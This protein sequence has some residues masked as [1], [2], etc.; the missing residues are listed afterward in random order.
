MNK[1]L[2][3]ESPEVTEDIVT[4]VRSELKD[5]TRLVIKLGYIKRDDLKSVVVPLFKG[6]PLIQGI[7]GINTI[8]M[9][10]L[11]GDGS[12]TFVGTEQK[13][14][15]H[16]TE[17][18]VSGIAIREYGLAFVRSLADIRQEYGL[19]F[20]II[21]MGGVMDAADVDAYQEAGADAVQTATA[22]FFNANLP[23]EIIRR[24][25]APATPEA[26]LQARSGIL[27]LLN[28]PDASQRTG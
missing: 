15:A 3:C 21:G 1:G 6:G 22:A 4:R 26:D 11:K 16:R 28:R 9:K 27:E 13:P 17:A 18:G 8:L 23:Q 20:D 5:Q 24:M 19:H 14:Q 2:I 7:S 25:G 12:P 10:V